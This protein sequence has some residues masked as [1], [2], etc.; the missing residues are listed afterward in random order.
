MKPEVARRTG[1]AEPS[2]RLIGG[3]I[4]RDSDTSTSSK[5]ACNGTVLLEDGKAT[6]IEHYTSDVPLGLGW[7]GLNSNTSRKTRLSVGE[8]RIMD[9]LDMLGADPKGAISFQISGS[10]KAEIANESSRQVKFPKFLS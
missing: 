9:K 4:H 7:G 5:S 8:V 10:K 1:S 3:V 2:A 6:Y